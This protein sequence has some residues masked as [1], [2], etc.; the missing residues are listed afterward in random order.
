MS[1]SI[2]DC[3]QPGSSVRGILQ[4]RIL[5]WVAVS[6][7]RGSSPPRDWTRVSCIEGWILNTE[8]LGKPWNNGRCMLLYL[9]KVKGLLEGFCLK[10]W[11]IPFGVSLRLFVLCICPLLLMKPQSPVLWKD[12]FPWE[13]THSHIPS[14][15][16]QLR[17][18]GRNMGKLWILNSP[19][20]WVDV[21][22]KCKSRQWTKLQVLHL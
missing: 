1:N 13:S 15:R 16:I 22:V 21:S 12:I 7:S 4:T 20:W 9:F 2:R 3:S 5:E 11:Y 10:K 14:D 17:G 8:P 18:S 6:S 19:D